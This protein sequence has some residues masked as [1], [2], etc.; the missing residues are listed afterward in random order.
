MFIP[1]YSFYHLDNDHFIDHALHDNYDNDNE[2]ND[3]SGMI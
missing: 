1:S 3:D 2:D